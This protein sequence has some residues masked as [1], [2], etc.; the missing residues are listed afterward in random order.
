MKLPHFRACCL[1]LLIPLVALIL[2]GC[3]GGKDHPPAQQP[4]V[5]WSAGNDK[6]NFRYNFLENI[7]T[8]TLY[9]ATPETGTFSHHS[10][11]TYVDGVFYAWWDNHIK[12]ENGSG[13]RGL[14]RRSTDQGKTWPPVEELFPPLDKMVPASEAY[15]GTIFQ[16]ANG[17]ALVDGIL[18]A[19]TD[20]AEWT[21]PGIAER[22]RISYG[23]LFRA[24]GPDGTLGEIFWLKEDPSPPAEGFPAYPAGDPELVNKINTF[25]DQP[26]QELQLIFTK[27]HPLSDDD[28][29][30]TEPTSSWKLEDGTLVRLYRDS[31]HKDAKTIG[32]EE[33]TKSRR[34]YA[35]FS[36]DN[37][38]TWSV[39]T[40]TSFPDACARS[41]AG[42]LPDSQVYVINNVLPLSPKKGGRALLAISLSRDGLNFDRTAVIRFLPP[43]M[44]YEGRAK[45]VGYQYPHSVVVGDDLWVMCSVNKEDI[46]VKRIPLEELYKIE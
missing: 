41:N 32:E 36:H 23:Q 9:E 22:S 7:E 11:I 14:L 19:V 20:V 28:H 10:H 39:P 40:R 18:Y 45:S 35:V 25:F 5:R 33:E 44:R 13:Q 34:N 15:I 1:V 43:P 37:G 42:K 4:V 38:K 31:G 24:V 3:R 12:D 27:P 17:F 30:L 26:G 29:R 46:E 21:G 16:T 6:M 8:T 2:T